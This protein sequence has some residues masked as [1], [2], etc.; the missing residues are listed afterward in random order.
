VKTAT[1]FRRLDIRYNKVRAK[2]QEGEFMFFRRKPPQDVAVELDTS[3]L[4]PGDSGRAIVTIQNRLATLGFH[5]GAIDGQYGP[6]TQ[7]AI[8]AFQRS[9]SLKPTGLIDNATL[10]ALGYQVDQEAPPPVRGGVS[11]ETLSQIFPHA[12]SNNLHQYYPILLR[13][14]G[15]KGLGDPLMILMAL[16]TIRVETSRFEPVSEYQSKYNTVPGGKPYALYDFRR[17]IGNNAVGDG[18]RYKGRGFIQLTGK[19]NYKTYSTQLG[20]GNLLVDQPDLAND[21][22]I[23]SRILASFLKDK[24]AIIRSALHR[25]DFAT[26]RKAVNGG[27]HGLPDFQLAFQIGKKEVGIIA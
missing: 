20:L 1:L 13:A 18:D 7:R 6:I 27:T 15:E 12:P 23:A 16:A 21:P 26:A 24:E 3:I 8:M 2:E 11:F 19:A 9:R 4:K 22:I 14:L 10:Q 17:D 25:E 5:Q